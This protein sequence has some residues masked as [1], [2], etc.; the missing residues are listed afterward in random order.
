V[1]PTNTPLPT[2]TVGPTVTPPPTATP[3]SLEAYQ[4]DVESTLD[5]FSGYGVSEEIYRDFIRGQL[6]REKLTESLAENQGFL[7]EDE[8]VSMYFLAFDTEEEAEEAAAVLE[9]DDFLTVWNTIRSRPN[10]PEST[11]TG[12]ASEVLWRQQSALV[13]LYGQAV[14]DAAFELDVDDV[15]DILVDEAAS[16]EE[17]D[18]YY[19][20]N[21]SGR[22]V[23]PLSESAIQQEK[24]QIMTNWLEGQARD[25]VETFDRWQQNVPQ[26]PVLNTRF[27]VAPTEAAPQPTIPAP[28]VPDESEEEPA[29]EE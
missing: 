24:E 8:M 16:E 26:Q 13:N 5:E 12:T 9:E 15:S 20:I 18:R 19:I 27:L 1:L 7:T 25:G 3:V 21:I 17:S 2:S 14:A 11:D 4:E 6:Y 28:V 23:R 10:D 22:E 29:P